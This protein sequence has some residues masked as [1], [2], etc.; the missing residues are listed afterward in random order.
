M[1]QSLA[2]LGRIDLNHLIALQVIL[3]EKHISRAA[4]RASIS[5]PA[6]SRILG[7]LRAVIGDD[8]VIRSGKAYERTPRGDQLLHDLGALL[9]RLND[10]VGRQAFD[11]STSGQR[12]RITG[13]DYAVTAIVGG[14]VRR[15]RRSAGGVHVEVV[16]WT[17]DSYHQTSV[18][19]CDLAV[20]VGSA[21]TVPAGL[22]VEVLYRERFVCLTSSDDRRPAKRFSLDEYLS[23][24]HAVIGT[25][26]RQ[27]TMIDRPLADLGKAR[28]VRFLSPYFLPT[29][30]D[31][32]GTDLV[33]TVP[34]RVAS[35][36]SNLATLR[37]VLPPKEIEDFSYVMVWHPRIDGDPGHV[38]FRDQVRHAAKAGD[39]PDLNSRKRETI[40][41]DHPTRVHRTRP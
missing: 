17:D 21:P 30:L 13:T 40:A 9:P 11:P 28:S 22:N 34:S 10:A 8:L 1:S 14:V 27:Q 24:P 15:C 38:W 12:F 16:G 2:N 31:V 25:A 23:R 3:E 41:D 7:R 33:I 18:G 32:V 5:Q 4:A 37:Q 19:R 35:L 29:A 20:G 26:G 36:L 6:M 39:P